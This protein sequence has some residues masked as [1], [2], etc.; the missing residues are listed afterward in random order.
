MEEALEKKVD[1][2]TKTFLIIVGV[3]FVG[4]VIA[5]IWLAG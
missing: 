4:A 5:C 3:I 2:L 1:K